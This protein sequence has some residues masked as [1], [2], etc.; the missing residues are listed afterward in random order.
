MFAEFRKCVLMLLQKAAQHGRYDIRVGQVLSGIIN[1]TQ[2][3]QR[4]EAGSRYS[5]AFRYVAQM[6]PTLENIGWAIKDI[7]GKKHFS[8][9]CPAAREKDY[10]KCDVCD[11]R[12]ECL[13]DPLH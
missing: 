3:F 4:Y 6:K 8:L 13:L 11:K 12:V 10:T 9:I 7:D 1:H 5:R 2:L